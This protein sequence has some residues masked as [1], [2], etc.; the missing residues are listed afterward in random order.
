MSTPEHSPIL[1]RCDVAVVGGSAAGLAAALQ[2][3]R[4]QRSVIVVDDGTPRNAPA[5][6]MHG[7]LG[8]DGHAP[9]TLVAH[10]RDEIRRYGGEILQGRVTTVER[11]A[12]GLFHL[13]LGHVLLAARRVVA[14]TGLIDRLPAI[15]GLAEQW[16]AAVI[17]CPFCHGYEVRDRRVVQIAAHPI[18]LHA[19]PLWA[20]LAGRFDLVVAF[21]PDEQAADRLT[22][23]TT[24]GATIHRGEAKRVTTDAAG[25]LVGVELADGIVL[26]ADA[27]AVSGPAAPRIEPFTALGLTAEA[28][29]S[30]AGDHVVTD[31]T[32]RTSIDGLYAAGNVTDPSHQVLHAAAHGSRVGAMVALDLATDPAMAP[33]APTPREA[34]WDGRYADDQVWSG[35]PNG[36]LVAEVADLKPGRALDVG[37]GEGGDALWLAE[38][39]WAVTATDIARSGLDRLTAEADRRHLTI[40][41]LH[42][43][44]N[45]LH[46]FG[47]E[48]YDLVTLFYSAIHR[49]DDDRAPEQLLDA[50]APGGTLLMVGHAPPEAGQEADRDAT[51]GSA[52]ANDRP[53]SPWDRHS[54]VTTEHLEAA[55][56]RRAGWT[57]QVDETRERPPGSATHGHHDRD[58]VLRATAP[59]D[60][61]PAR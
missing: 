31:E 4:Q 2:L 36:S 5:A 40:A 6:H 11:T 57:I 26:P 60:T 47:S 50:V 38:Q 21:E 9:A 61:P 29:P 10:G 49:T 23:L 13:D 46:P 48:R 16:G 43:D 18:A 30:G 3:Q 1:R 58:V 17:H 39:G 44:A 7:Y 53:G 51:L 14:A 15:D 8:F 42:V 33:A 45:E 54:F 35:R 56:R 41:T 22:A 52:T 59:D 25:T 27:V 12:D 20:H 32:G 24:A 37:A 34:E 28:H 55:V 19:A